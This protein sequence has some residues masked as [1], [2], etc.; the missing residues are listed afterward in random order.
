MNT[1]QKKPDML[2]VFDK[3]V[4]REYYKHVSG[5]IFSHDESIRSD[6]LENWKEWNISCDSMPD[7]VIINGEEF[8]LI[9]LES[10]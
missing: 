7:K 3:Y 1:Q 8:E 5:F 10:K 2:Q 6:R 9:R 4:D